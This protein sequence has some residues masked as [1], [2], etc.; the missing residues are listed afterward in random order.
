MVVE[1]YLTDIML[2][3]EFK[4]TQTE[5]EVVVAVRL[6][7]VKVSSCEFYIEEHTFKL[8]LKPYLLSLTFEECLQEA[9]EPAKAIYYQ[10]KYILEVRLNKKQVGEHFQNLNLLSSLL[11]TKKSKKKKTLVE[12]IGQGPQVDESA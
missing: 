1:I 12:V 10:D 7:Y 8:Y 9:E 6:P 4:I 11:N 5:A 3:P 2:T